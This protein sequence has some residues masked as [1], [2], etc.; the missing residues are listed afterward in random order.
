MATTTTTT[1]A[2]SAKLESVALSGK[3]SG[4]MRLD[5]EYTNYGDWRDDLN[6]DGYAVIKGAIPRLRADGY[7]DQ[8][9][10][11]MENL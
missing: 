1:T 6:R 4:A 7:S 8:F 11:Y 5:G 2:T 3:S 10:S 9:Y